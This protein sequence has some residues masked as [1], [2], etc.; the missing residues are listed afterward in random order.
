MGI[1][2]DKDLVKFSY[3]KQSSTKYDCVAVPRKRTWSSV[4]VL[5]LHLS[6]CFTSLKSVVPCAYLRSSG[7]TS[8]C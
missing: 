1:P 3:H 4:L 5:T 6:T 7:Y 2:V 8:V